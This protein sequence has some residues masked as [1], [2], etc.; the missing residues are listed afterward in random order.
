MHTERSRTQ[1][2]A[3][4]DERLSSTR[5]LT[6]EIH[7]GRD[8]DTSLRCF[9]RLKRDRREV[10]NLKIRGVTTWR[11]VPMLTASISMASKSPHPPVL[12]KVQRL[13]A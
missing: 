6:R 4:T 8:G 10:E 5:Q 12:G 3:L 7:G 11:A 9:W 1:I 2:H 13:G